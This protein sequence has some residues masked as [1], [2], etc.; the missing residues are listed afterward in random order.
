MVKVNSRQ[1]DGRGTPKRT[2]NITKL[3]SQ[4]CMK[5]EDRRRAGKGA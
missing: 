1:E 2:S 3:V 5:R 4:L